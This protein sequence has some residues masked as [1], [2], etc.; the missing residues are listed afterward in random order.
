MKHIMQRVEVNNHD[1][2]VE[3]YATSTITLLDATH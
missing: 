1:T 3:L 2:L